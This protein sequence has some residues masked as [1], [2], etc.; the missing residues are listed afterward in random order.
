MPLDPQAR[1]VMDQVA[2]LGLPPAHTVT[3][4]EARANAKSRPRAIGPDVGKVEDRNIPGP[5][6]EI[7]IRI[8]LSLIHI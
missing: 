2:A 4:Q 1:A 6:S 7:P 3:P 8:Y 5:D